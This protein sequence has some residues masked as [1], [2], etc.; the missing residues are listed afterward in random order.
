MPSNGTQ[1]WFARE[2]LVPAFRLLLVS[3]LGLYFE[4]T[5]IRWIPTQVRLLAYFTNFVLIAAL[6]GL[7]L[8]ML[9]AVRKLRLVTFFPMALLVL[10]GLVLILARHN[11]VL[12]LVTQGEFMWGY[13]QYLPG[14]GWF[15]YLVLVGF[16]ILMVG[17]FAFIGQEVG[18]TLRAFP[19]LTAYAIN[20]FASL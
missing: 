9:L 16:F 8:G 19:P 6:L 18:R 12:P 7:G 17:V 10:T 4:L 20:I 13:V 3:F 1:A 2:S 15:S 14:A 5:L 11:L